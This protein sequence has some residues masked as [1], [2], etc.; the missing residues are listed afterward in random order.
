MR[1]DSPGCDGS[2]CGGCPGDFVCHCLKITEDMVLD[3]VEGGARSVRD[4]RRQIGAG[5]GCMAC[6]RRLSAYIEHAGRRA[7][8]LVVQ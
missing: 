4:L 2:R 5:D 3:A 7:L 6:H 8:E 1:E